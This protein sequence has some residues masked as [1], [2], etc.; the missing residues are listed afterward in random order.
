MTN[1]PLTVTGTVV[2]GNSL[3]NTDDVPTAN[4]VPR[5][6][7]SGLIYGVYRSKMTIDGE[8][9]DSITNLGTRPTVSDRGSMNAESFVKDFKGDL[10]NK[11]IS[12]TLLEFVRP[13]R[14]FSSFD[15]L[16]AQIKEDI[17]K[18]LFDR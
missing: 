9:Y 6:D 8:E 18:N 2:H 15:E 12:L 11:E 4:I 7:V 17:Q 10:Y 13:E 1:L 16:A 14:R 5:E 3:G